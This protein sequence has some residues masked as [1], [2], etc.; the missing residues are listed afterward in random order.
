MRT[1]SPQKIVEKCVLECRQLSTPD[2]FLYEMHLPEPTDNDSLVEI[3]Q[4]AALK[5]KIDDEQWN[6]KAFAFRS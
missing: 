6:L 4:N 2:N 3:L 1:P 5:V